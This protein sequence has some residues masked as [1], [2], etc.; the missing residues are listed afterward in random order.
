MEDLFLSESNDIVRKTLIT[1]AHSI[2]VKA[3]SQF[4]G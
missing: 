1:K 3:G 4:A 2:G